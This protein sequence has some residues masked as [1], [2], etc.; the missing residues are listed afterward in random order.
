MF[1]DEPWQYTT[2]LD[3][4]DHWQSGLAGVLGFAAAIIAVVIALGSEQ[5]K[6]RRELRIIR[7]SLGVEIRQYTANSYN[8]HLFCRAIL[9]KRPGVIPAIMIEDKARLPDPTIYPNV[10]TRISELGDCAAEI[11]L[12]YNRIAVVRE[13]AERLLRHPFANDLPNPEIRE[14]ADGLIKIA[15]TG[16]GLLPMLKTGIQSEDGTDSQAINKINETWK[17]WPDIKAKF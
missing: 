15:I 10:A 7:K 4:L 9:L 8:A 11:V 16:V 5:R 13:G 17:Q 2:F 1:F 12:F 14:A 3:L 6:H